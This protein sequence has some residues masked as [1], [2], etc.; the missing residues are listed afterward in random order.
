MTDFQHTIPGL[1]DAVACATVDMR[2]HAPLLRAVSGFKPLANVKFAT[3]R[4][5][6]GSISLVKQK[7]IAPDG[8]VIADDREPWVREQLKRHDGKVAACIASL[9][10]QK[11]RIATC[12][13]VKLYLVQDNGGAQTNFLQVEIEVEIEKIDRNLLNENAW[14]TPR[15]E[16]D[17]L[18]LTEGE[19]LPEEDQVPLCPARYCLVRIVDVEQL[20]GM[21]DEREAQDRAREAARRYVLRDSNPAVA[22]GAGE[23]VTGL[24]INPGMYRNPG[25]YRRFFEDW[26]NSSA[27]RSGARLCDHWT[28]QV[29]DWT[30]PKTR[31]RWLSFVPMWTFSKRLAEVE[32]RKGDDYAFYSKLQTLD[33]RVDVPFGWYFYMLHGNRVH[34]A[35][36]HRARRIAEAGL[37]VMPECDY[38]VLLR[39]CKD[40]YGF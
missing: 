8:Q 12:G 29:S 27:G 17:L 22:A 1:A 6:D 39:W 5:E 35:A 24:D 10:E 30:D 34:D 40:S 37:I 38:Q 15:D 2:K 33:R 32:A 20:V 26:Q 28:L 7:V 11:L 23:V 4:G 16:A 19:R 14:F 9:K 31:V 21:L 3:T 36:G 13:L 25:K 18:S